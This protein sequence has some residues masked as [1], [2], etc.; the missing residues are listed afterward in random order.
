MRGIIQ[1]VGQTSIRKFIGLS[2]AV[3]VAFLLAGRGSGLVEV[4]AQTANC[5]SPA[6]AIVA[7]NCLAGDTDW[8]ITENDPDIQGF[9]TD[10][11]VNT[12]ETVTFKINTDATEYRIDIYRLG[13]YGGDGARKV[14]SMTVVGAQVQPAC[15]TDAATG[16]V[17]CGTWSPS[18]S[19]ETT[20][21]TSG[22]YIA[23]LVRTDGNPTT[24]SGTSHIVF[25]VRDDASTSDL[26]FQTSDTTWQA[27]N[28]YGGNSLYDG[29]PGVSP[30][31]AYKVSYNRPFD[32]RD[33]RP[34]S[35]VFN[36][37]YP[38]VRW[39]EANGYDVTYFTG[40]DSDRRGAQILNHKSFLSVGHD[41]YWSAAQRAHVEAARD[42]G[43]NLA[44]FSGNSVFWKTRWESS[45]DGSNTPYRTLVSYKETH[46]NAKI[47]PSSAWTGTWRDPRFS[48]PSDGGRPE[49]A[50]TGTLW[51]VNCCTYAITV[52]GEMASHRFW[53]NTEVAELLPGD[54][55]TLSAN[56]LGYEWDEDIDNGFR[57]AGLTRLSQTTIEVPE[58]LI[59]NGS[60]T[61]P[62]VATHALTLYRTNTIDPQGNP[63]SAL[64]F[65]AGTV[66][67]SWGLDGSHDRGPSIP[68]VRM[69]QATVNLFVD[70]G[71]E[72]GSIQPGL[73]VT[74]AATDSNAPIA[75]ITSPANGATVE[76]GVRVTV[77]GTADDIGGSVASVEVSVDGGATW[78]LANGTTNWT[79]DWIPGATGNASIQSRATDDSSNVGAASAPVVVT[80]GASTCP[81]CT[82]LWNHDVT[83][84]S[85]VDGGDAQ[86]VEL[87]VKFSSDVAGF[88]TGIRF[89]KAPTNT[90]T[91]VGNL[92]TAGGT[93]LATAVFTSE[94]ASGW[95]RV[96]FDAPVEILPNT[97]Y[98]ASYHTNVGHYSVDRDYF[99]TVGVDS[100]PLH[101]PAEGNGLFTY[102]VS[103]FPTSTFRATNYWVDIDFTSTI[104]GNDGPVISDIDA[105]AIDGTT[106]GISWVTNEDADSQ[107]IYSTNP[108]FPPSESAAVT[109]AVFVKQHNFQITG[110]TSN[111]TYYFRIASTDRSGNANFAL[112]PDRRCTIPHRSTSAAARRESP[113][114]R[115]A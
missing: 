72:P 1:S 13:Y 78:H 82:S 59:D 21:A 23:K 74:T 29:G 68:D 111:A 66:Q 55:L 36:A 58:R 105:V 109:S 15:L 77:R 73:V 24:S 61:A 22:I 99:E 20:G 17:D 43:V 96:S 114:T 106:A 6:N 108:S 101:A 115:T 93:L 27:Y 4:L 84:P 38:M 65:G 9:A 86:A 113:A 103:Q 11:S 31:R 50:L 5:L 32:T 19:W 79:Y 104:E 92:W 85:L 33:D 97:T 37:E 107:I 41:E 16:L 51:T 8:D 26:L 34:E 94:T 60:S 42:A 67:W 87:G 28:T 53:R 112:C 54:S 47:D 35:W 40:V 75:T 63:R 2:A 12:G 56:T 39:L 110:L 18:A 102:G 80:I 7:E 45:I 30:A 10:I 64:V 70:M 71:V 81:P 48:P 25:V 88:I 49:N 83:V 98:V 44:F 100:A 52:P 91:H 69:Q 90:G 14:T 57:P 95:Q 46:A 89:Y 3:A 76:S 62:G